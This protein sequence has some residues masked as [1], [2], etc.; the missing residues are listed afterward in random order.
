MMFI[1][2]EDESGAV[3]NERQR[4]ADKAGLRHVSAVGAKQDGKPDKS[5]RLQIT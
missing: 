5:F 3:G 1:F 4:G 2:G